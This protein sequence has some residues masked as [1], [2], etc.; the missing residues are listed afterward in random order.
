MRG[1]DFEPLTLS[2]CLN[3]AGNTEL[4]DLSSESPTSYVVISSATGVAIIVVTILGL[5]FA[6][7]CLALLVRWREERVLKSASIP[8]SVLMCLGAVVGLISNFLFLERPTDEICNARAWLTGLGF[9]VFI[10]NFLVKV[11]RIYVIFSTKVLLKINIPDIKLHIYSAILLGVQVVLLSLYTG[12]GQPTVRRVALVSHYSLYDTV[13]VTSESEIWNL[14]LLVY[15]A[16]LL[17]YGVYL[18]VQVRNF[19][20]LFNEARLLAG[21]IYNMIF[22]AVVCGP[23]LLFLNMPPTSSA[24]IRALASFAMFTGSL[25]IVFIPKFLMV[26]SSEP[27]QNSG[28]NGSKTTT[29]THFSSVTIDFD[30]LKSQDT[31]T[32]VSQKEKA[33]A[34][35]RAIDA[36]IERRSITLSGINNSPLSKTRSSMASIQ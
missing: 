22:V 19:V 9:V 21:S 23:I 15:A 17:L 2:F 26:N 25:G 8:F 31:N 13:C 27:S 12:I 33:F 3:N 34:L 7:V 10:G 11:W 6:A 1:A 30:S 5:L 4:C 29:D 36:E 18:A 16:L 35:V 14:L 20:S 24:L 28:S 32:L